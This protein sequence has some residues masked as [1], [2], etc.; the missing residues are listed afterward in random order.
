[1]LAII[2]HPHRRAHS[3]VSPSPSGR[4]SYAIEERGANLSGGQQP[5]IAI[6]RALATN[7]RILILDEA[8]LALDYNSERIIHE[9]MRAIVRGRRVIIIAHRLAVEPSPTCRSGAPAFC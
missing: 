9:N 3:S 5:R 2:E 7:P 1:M 6:A 4:R 8:A